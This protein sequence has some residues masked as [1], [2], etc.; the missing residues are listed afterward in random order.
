MGTG[1]SDSAPVVQ[2]RLSRRDLHE[3]PV[4]QFR[5]WFAD[6]SR[7]EG[8]DATAMTLATADASGR[9]SARIVLLKAFDEEGFRF[10]TNYNSQKGRE[11]VQNPQATLLFWWE[12]LA[13]QVRI[14]GEV[15]RVKESESDAYFQSRIRGSQIGAWASPQSE[16]IPSRAFLEERLE[17]AGRQFGDG[18]VA[19]PPHWGGFCLIPEE[20]EFW[21]G[22]Y[23]RLHDR[24]RY[25]RHHERWVIER[26]GP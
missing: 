22:G 11:L 14:T 4:E 18:A 15:K 3:N 10:F 1:K 16:V 8:R 23:N 12:D 6:A 21:L 2:A 24:F 13:R 26:L 19:R 5:R 17:E 20:F 7:L 9:P 25:L